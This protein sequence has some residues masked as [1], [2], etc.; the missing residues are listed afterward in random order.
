MR[1][2]SALIWIIAALLIACSSESTS[3][4][5]SSQERDEHRRKTIG[6]SDSDR[7][8]H[9]DAGRGT[10]TGSVRPAG[11]HG[12]HR[13]SDDDRSTGCPA[14]N[15]NGANRHTTGADGDCATNGDPDP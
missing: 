1:F 4:P 5:P 15:G 7:T 12:P 8:A 14:S 3:P 2:A 6:G 11:A 13:S 9:R 10:D